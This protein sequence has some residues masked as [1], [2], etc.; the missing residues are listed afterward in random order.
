M[1]AMKAV[2]W[3]KLKRKEKNKQH[4]TTQLKSCHFGFLLTGSRIDINFSGTTVTYRPGLIIGGKVNHT[5]PTSKAI[6]YFLEPIICLA[7]FAKKPMALT[8]DGVTN[9]DIDPSVDALR[10]VALPLLRKFGVDGL[11]LKIS[12]RGAPPLGGGQ[13]REWSINFLFHSLSYCI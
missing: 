2:V 9:N 4:A 8:L 10:T 13:V 11:E 7:P 1:K 3:I 5:C 6:G 12:R